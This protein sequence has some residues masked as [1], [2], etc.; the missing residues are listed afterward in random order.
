MEIEGNMIIWTGL[1]IPAG[2]EFFVA[3]RVEAMEF[4]PGRDFE[5]SAEITSAEIEDADSTPGNADQGLN[6]DDESSIVTAPE[7]TSSVDLGLTMTAN[8]QVVTP[9]S[10]IEYIL[11]LTNNGPEI[12]TG[13][14]ITNYLA[15][16]A[17]ENIAEITENG[18]LSDNQIVWI[19]EEIGVGETIQLSF[20]ADVIDNI[21]RDDVR[22]AAEITMASQFDPNSAPDNMGD[23]PAEN[24]EALHIASVNK[25][26]DL[27]LN[28]MD[29]ENLYEIGETVSFDIKL[30]NKGLDDAAMVKVVNYVPVGII[31]ISSINNGGV[32]I[33]NEIHWTIYDFDMNEEMMFTFSG[34]LIKVI[35]ECDAYLDRAEVFSSSSNDDDS[36]PGNIMDASED[37]DD[38]LEIGI[39]PT[40]CISVDARVFLEGAFVRSEDRMHNVLYQ[41][42]YL[43]GQAPQTFFGNK[44]EP[45]QPYDSEPWYHCGEEGDPFDANNE[46]VDDL[47]GYPDNTVDWVLVS[48]RSEASP[49]SVVCRKSALVLDDGEIFFVE[50]FD[51]CGID[52]DIEYYMVIEH[53][54][55]LPI[56]SP[57]KMPIENGKVSFDFTTT[58]SFVAL[59][60][61]GQKEVSPGRWVMIAGNGEQGDFIESG[62]INVN[63]LSRWSSE[64][65]DNS[66][67]YFTDF[68]L[69]GDVN[70]QDKGLVLRNFGVFSD[71]MNR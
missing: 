31:N 15:A 7:V 52:D 50:E 45:G 25:I 1:N 53:R 11:N 5:S 47:A 66:G 70:V 44:E 20:I 36:T 42:G 6:E 18:L 33:G 14:E 49:Q 39:A 62:D 16:G 63:D 29:D 64:E 37:D 27:E 71:V 12:G 17:V 24:D 61:T 65:G 34:E 38:A 3:Y 57:T 46:G 13:V 55:H 8:R 68:D 22:N 2:G 60:G 48:L 58:N 21:D 41:N 4:A 67:Y 54:N 28:I 10:T 56:M 35:S 30:V 26:A 40:Q 23:F 43:P 59:L 51:C 32:L 9:G 69:N 19:I